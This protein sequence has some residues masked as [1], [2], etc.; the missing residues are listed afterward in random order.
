MPRVEE[1][2][3]NSVVVI[4][5]PPGQTSHEITTFVKKI[6]GASRSGHAGTL[7]PEVSG[8]LPIALGR[9]TKL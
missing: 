9:A 3:K 1:L 7:D 8:V 6:T 4:N 5:K 2:L